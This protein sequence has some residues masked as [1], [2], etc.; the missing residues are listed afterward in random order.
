MPSTSICLMNHSVKLDNSSLGRQ[1]PW[2]ST[3]VCRY[4]H[5]RREDPVLITGTATYVD[6]RSCRRLRSCCTAPMP[7][8][9][10]RMTPSR[11]P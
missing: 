9:I 3:E 7:G 5:K 6:D 10:V 2:Q 11:T 8:R 1:L 4:A